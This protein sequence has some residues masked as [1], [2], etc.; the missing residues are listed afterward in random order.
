VLLA[1]RSPM[2]SSPMETVLFLPLHSASTNASL[3]FKRC[4][5]SQYCTHNIQRVLL[6]YAIHLFV[7]TLLEPLLPLFLTLALV[8]LHKLR[9]RVFDEIALLVQARPFG[10][11]IRN[12]HNALAVEHVASVKHN[13]SEAFDNTRSPCSSDSPRLEVSL[14]LICL[15]VDQAREQQDHVPALIHNR[16][17]A[18]RAAD[19]A[20][21][22][23]LDALVR[24][25]IPLEIVVAV[26]EVDVVLVE[27]GGP[28]KG[29]G[30]ITDSM[31]AR[32]FH[33]VYCTRPGAGRP[34]R[35]MHL[36]C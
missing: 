20:R 9:R 14:I 27:D 10:Q 36:P 3:L 13:V 28:L 26:E 18:V 8:L 12:V 32:R 19:L 33:N 16:A 31:S 6:I 34:S 35:C 15:Q 7:L 23:V 2:Q 17:V 30:Y 21:Q 25:V 1:K 11:T 5:R 4:P 29:C 22:L 24:R